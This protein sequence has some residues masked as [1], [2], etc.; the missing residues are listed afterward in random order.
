MFFFEKMLKNFE[1][2]VSKILR[3]APPMR[4]QFGCTKA[5]KYREKKNVNCIAFK[6]SVI[7][8][9]VNVLINYIE[10]KYKFANLVETVLRRTQR[11]MVLLD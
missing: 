3:A 2:R 10:S 5:R 11:E 1:K 9:Y 6:V 8:A 4:L 7:Q